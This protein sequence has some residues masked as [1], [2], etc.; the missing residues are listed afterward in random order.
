MRGRL[1][2]SRG[3]VKLSKVKPGREELSKVKV[4]K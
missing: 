3:K 1:I 4:K 2:V